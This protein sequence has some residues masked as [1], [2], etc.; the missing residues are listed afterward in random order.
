M[1]GKSIRTIRKLNENKYIVATDAEGFYKIDVKENTE[2]RIKILEDTTELAI[3]Y[4]R[5]IFIGKDNT[6][7]IGDSDDLYTGFKF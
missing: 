3:N 1:K 6:F 4:S 5:D 7:I 2:E